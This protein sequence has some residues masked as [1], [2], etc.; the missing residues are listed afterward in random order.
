MY[1]HG[2]GVTRIGEEQPGGW[3]YH[4]SDALGSVRQL[5]DDAAQITLARG[6]TPYGEPL[7]SVGSGSS[8]YGYTGEDWNTT[9]QL[10]F[11]RAR[12]MQPTLGVF[13]SRDPWSGDDLRPLTYNG[14]AY[15]EG[16]PINYTDPTGYLAQ[17][18]EI[19]ADNIR[20]VL[21]STYN[22]VIPKDYGVG[23]IGY[24]CPVW[25]T[26]AWRTLQELQWT[27]AAI[28]DMATT[29]GGGNKFERAMNSPVTIVRRGW[30]SYE[31]PVVG[32][33]RA[34][35]PPVGE[36]LSDVDL[37]DYTF[38]STDAD[39]KFGV[40][41]ELGHVWDRRRGLQ[42]ADG[43]GRFLG[44]VRCVS[45]GMGGNRCWFD[46]TA[47][48]EAPPGFTRVLNLNDWKKEYAAGGSMEDWA[49]AVASVVYP[50][51]YGTL[52]QPMGPLRRQYVLDQIRAIR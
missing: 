49:E 28:N 9:I 36:I 48:R 19:P 13:L 21:Q 23:N 40:V 50:A 38:S 4:L 6:S 37:P 34:F 1:L 47:G 16:N 31:F 2:V 46:I 41:H 3:A 24:G 26:G 18:D 22:V 15:V 43:M 20:T 42:L 11:L 33:I 25:Q 35:A 27:E 45:E 29:M 51:Y 17:Q 14:W 30:T 39:A 5:A 52:Y 10:V 32:P 8:A 7:W 12:Y 44:T